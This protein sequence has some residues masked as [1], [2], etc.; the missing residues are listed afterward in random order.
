MNYFLF[1]I[2]AII[3]GSYFLDLIVERLNVRHLKTELPGE[4]AGYY[5]QERYKKSQEYIPNN[6]FP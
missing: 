6:F 2:L 3:I 4:F 1:I 5:N